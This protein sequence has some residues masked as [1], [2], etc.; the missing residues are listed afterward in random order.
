MKKVLLLGLMIV[1]GCAS[2][3]K[4][5]VAPQVRQVAPDAVSS[6]HKKLQIQVGWLP[7]KNAEV[8]NVDGSRWAVSSGDS[9]GAGEIPVMIVRQGE[10][11]EP[12]QLGMDIDDALLGKLLKHS[13]MTEVPI[14]RPFD[15]FLKEADCATCHPS[16]VKIK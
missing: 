6:F 14:K 10:D 1:A 2:A 12:V 9:T 3:P 11:G 5:K 4:T 7:Y 13:L 16:S 15:E 8:I